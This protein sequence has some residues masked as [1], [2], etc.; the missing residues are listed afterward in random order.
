LVFWVYKNLQ[1]CSYCLKYS[2]YRLNNTINKAQKAKLYVFVII[3]YYSVKN[4]EK[5]NL[6]LNY[7]KP[8]EIKF[9]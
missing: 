5:F 1:L 7:R 8:S 2:W 9:K 4:T 6:V 3:F